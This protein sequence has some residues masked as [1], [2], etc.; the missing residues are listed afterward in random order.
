MVM[1]LFINYCQDLHENMKTNELL[2][3]MLPLLSKESISSDKFILNAANVI[4]DRQYHDAL[5]V[6]LTVLAGYAVSKGKSQLLPLVWMKL[7][8]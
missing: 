5:S 6:F 3:E 1:H 4:R 8:T 7:N 2:D